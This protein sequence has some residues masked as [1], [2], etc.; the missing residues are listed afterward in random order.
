MRGRCSVK[1]NSPPVKSAPGL[2]SRI[3]IW[4]GKASS[5]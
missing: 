2:D 5:P 1:T 3:A 4:R